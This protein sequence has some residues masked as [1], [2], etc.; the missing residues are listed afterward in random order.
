M[1]TITAPTGNIGRQVVSRLLR[2]GDAQLRVVA[3]DPS[4]LTDDVRARAHVVTGSHGDPETASAAFGGA[5]AVFWLVPPDPR[6]HSVGAAYLDFTRP[7]C[8]VLRGGGVRRV[9]GISALGRGVARD[10]GLVTASL[11][12]DDLIAATGVSYRALTLPSFMDNLLRQADSIMNR[13]VF[14]SPIDGDLEMPSC[15]TR[16]IADVAAALLLDDSWS[17]TSDVPVLGP[18][19]LSFNQMATTMSEV[20]ERPV[21]FQQ[22]DGVAYKQNLL[23][24]GMSEPMAQAMLDMANAKNAGLDNAGPRTAEASTP[25]TFRQWCDDVL[26]PA[27]M[28]QPI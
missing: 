25:T 1:I 24:G 15:A 5:D 22:I 14:F 21:R 16:D 3:R 12:M 8:A 28:S 4:R 23:A 19:D 18:E 26:R 6:A 2:S 13:G 9:V 27:L 10:A 11:E 7:A 17:G 20:L